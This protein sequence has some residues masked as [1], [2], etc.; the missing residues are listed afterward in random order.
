MDKLENIKDELMKVSEEVLGLDK[1]EKNIWRKTD[2]S[3]LIYG[4]Y[5]ALRIVETLILE[6]EK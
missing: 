1:D 6:K 3:S 5:S 4:I 2:Y